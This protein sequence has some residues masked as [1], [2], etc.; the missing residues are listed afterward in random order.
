MVIMIVDDN[1]K[2]REMIKRELLINESK[3]SRIMECE[4]GLHAIDEYAKVKPDWVLMDIEMHPVN[5]ITAL[6]IIKEKNP[7]AKIIIITQYDEPE[8]RRAAD[9]AGAYAFVLKEN[10]DE[11]H[12]ILHNH[13]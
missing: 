9:I 7:E 8:Y 12:T 11:L 10:I 13:I 5:G 3:V 4:N 6:Q 1:Y 2:I